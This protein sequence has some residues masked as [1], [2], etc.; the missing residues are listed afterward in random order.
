LFQPTQAPYQA[1]APSAPGKHGFSPC[2]HFNARTKPIE[3]ASPYIKLAFLSDKDIFC[4]TVVNT[5]KIQLRP[6]FAGSKQNLAH[7]FAQHCHTGLT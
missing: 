6:H 4:K 5:A 2:H 3:R 1:F 7:R